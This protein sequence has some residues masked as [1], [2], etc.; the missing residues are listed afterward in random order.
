MLL[1]LIHIPPTIQKPTVRIQKYFSHNS[2][3]MDWIPVNQLQTYIVF[4]YKT[5][6]SQSCVHS[7]P[8]LFSRHVRT[9]WPWQFCT[10]RC[11]VH[12]EP[13]H[14]GYHQRHLQCYPQLHFHAHWQL[15]LWWV[16]LYTLINFFAF[17]RIAPKILHMYCSGV[18]R[19]Y[20]GSLF[21]WSL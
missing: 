7:G 18:L 13:V 4:N 20:L 21:Y 8:I 15:A 12:S 11:C 16:H 5:I 14:G 19:S 9:V 2:K 10:E 6:F 3:V 17:C 1:Q